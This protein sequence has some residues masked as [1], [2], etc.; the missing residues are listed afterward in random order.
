[1]VNKIVKGD[2]S[3]S[4]VVAKLLK[5]GYTV[6]EPTSENSRYDLVIDLN[7]KFVRAQVK[8]IY[9]KNDKKVYE[10]VCYSVTRRNKKH[11]RAQYTEKEIDVIIGYNQ[12][13]DEVYTFPIK[14]IN[15]RNQIIFRDKR[16]ANQHNP[17]DISK[18]KDFIHLTKD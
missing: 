6:L 8:T 11:I 7:G 14:D 5:E 18:Y 15:G 2:I 4:F 3:K 16:Q 12:D 17:L 1:M 9:Y 13:N 10:M